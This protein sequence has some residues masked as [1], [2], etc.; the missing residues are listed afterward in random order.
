MNKK[1]VWAIVAGVF[2]IILVTTMADILLHVVR[3]FPPMNQPLDDRLSA[4][5]TS[6]R[7]V[8]GV[9]GAYLT[10]R[11][12]PDRPMRHAIILGAVGI[13][14]GLIGVIA[15]WNAGL[16]PRWYPM[17]LVVLALPQSWAGG[18]WFVMQASQSA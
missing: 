18:K 13:V 3:V 15:T 16:S 4:V 7:I 17:L 2:F 6:Y 5:A 14:L 10:A 12:A 8:I 9:A 11:L 1:S